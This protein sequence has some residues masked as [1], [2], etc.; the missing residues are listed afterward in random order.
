MQVYRILKDIKSREGVCEA[1]REVYYDEQHQYVTVD[2]MLIAPQYQSIFLEIIN[3][4]ALKKEY[5]KEV[6][7]F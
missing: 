3:T 5:L 6:R 1:G 7:Y 2:G 4:P